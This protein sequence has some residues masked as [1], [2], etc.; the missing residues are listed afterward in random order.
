MTI[1]PAD[2]A[3]RARAIRIAVALAV[4]F[5]GLLM[6]FQWLGGEWMTH[7]VAKQP[8]WL[9]V[10]GLVFMMPIL[11]FAVLAFRKGGQAVRALRFPVP[12][13]RVIRPTPVREGAAAIR[14]GRLMQLL[15]VLLLG[16]A[17]GIPWL[18]WR[19]AESFGT[20]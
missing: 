14:V 5:A 4:L 8:M 16:C 18:L 9:P 15:S 10:I 13:D 7:R 12:G 3:A 20:M 11:V 2:P 1:Q 19:L 17:L 6:A